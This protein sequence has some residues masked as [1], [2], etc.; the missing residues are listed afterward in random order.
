MYTSIMGFFRNPIHF[1]R[2]SLQHSFSWFSMFLIFDPLFDLFPRY[3]LWNGKLLKN[4]EK[5]KNSIRYLKILLLARL[6]RHN[7]SQIFSMQPISNFAPFQC[8]F[9]GE[10]FE[11]KD[12]SNLTLW[13]CKKHIYNRLFS[14]LFFFFFLLCLSSRTNDGYRYRFSWKSIRKCY[15]ERN[16]IFWETREMILLDKHLFSI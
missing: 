2:S 14:C 11:R 5:K 9:I 3:R 7:C 8:A 13:L 15:Y 4:F 16:L 12:R 1:S 10:L 6:Q